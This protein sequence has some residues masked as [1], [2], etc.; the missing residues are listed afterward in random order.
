MSAPKIAVSSWTELDD[1]SL[2]TFS[3]T[4]ANVLSDQVA[5]P[6]LIEETKTL[7]DAASNFNIAYSRYKQFGG[8]ANREAKDSARANLYGAHATVAAK[9]EATVGDDLTYLTK[10]GYRLE[11][12]GG[13]R[14]TAKVPPPVLQKAESAK[15]RGRVLIILKAQQTRTIKGVEG[16]YSLDN[17]LTWHE[18]IHQVKLSFNLEDQPSGKT[19]IYQFRFL[20]TNNRISDWSAHIRVDVY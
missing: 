4:A 20:A 3:T 7:S 10:P 1:A 16:R 17:G 13:R 5:Y 6:L 14:S 12:T 2:N 15:V 8:I 11:G 19:V 9:L 18:G